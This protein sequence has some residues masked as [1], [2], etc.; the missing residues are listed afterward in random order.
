MADQ[1]PAEVLPRKS[2][3][4]PTSQ[5]PRYAGPVASGEVKPGPKPQVHDQDVLSSD[6]RREINRDYGAVYLDQVQR[7]EAEVL[8]AK[9]EGREPDL[10]NPPAVQGTPLRVKKDK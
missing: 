3:E 6:P 4:K 2:V 1:K 7:R 8:R 10:D 9:V 5:S